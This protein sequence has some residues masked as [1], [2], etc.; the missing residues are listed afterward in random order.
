VAVRRTPVFLDGGGNGLA[1]AALF[2]AAARQ[3]SV[4]LKAVRGG[5]RFDPLGALAEDG[6]LTAGLDRSL[7]LMAHLAAWCDANAPGL[8]ALTVSTVPY[9]TSGA[10]AVQELAYA[11]ATGVLY[12]RHLEER[13]I[14][15]EAGARQLDF[16]F[17]VGRDTFVEM[18]K[19][20]AFRRLW[21]Q[22][23]AACGVDDPAPAPVHAVTSPRTLTTRDPWVNLLRVTSQVFAAV[24]GGAETITTQPF[25]AAVG[26]PGDLGRR[27]A[28]NTHTILREESHLHHVAD[29]AGGSWY[30]E[31]L[32]D[33]L[34]AAG[35]DA[36]RA[37]EADGG[38]RRAFTGGAVAEQLSG[39]LAAA[40][41]DLAT[42]KRPVTG[43][44]TWPN[45]NEKPVKSPAIDAKGLL[46]KRL[47]S[48][49]AW[50]AGHDTGNATKALADATERGDDALM[51][52]AIEAAAQGATATEL[53]DALRSGSRANR[54]V[55]LGCETEAA[56]FERLR[57]AADAHAAEHGQ[58]PR[59]FLATLGPIPE[60]K[61]RATFAKNFFE[62][63]G[64]V[65]T[66]GGALEGT[67]AVVAAYRAAGTDRVCLCSS[68]AR[69]ADQAADVARALK[70]AGAATVLLAGRMGDHE[71]TLPRRRHRRRHLP[72]VRCAGH[73]EP[74]AHRHGG[75][76]MSRI[77]DFAN[78]E[79]PPQSAGDL[80]GW[81]ASART[82]AG[83]DLDQR[84]WATPEGIDVKPLY[85]ADDLEGPCRACPP[86][87]A[88]PTHHVRQR[89]WTIRQ[90]AGFSTAEESNAFYRR[91]LA[92]GQ[93]GLSVA[94]DLATHRGYD[95]D[96]PRVAGDVGMAGV[97]I[98]SIYDMRTLFDGIPLDKMSVSMTMNGAVLPVMALY[99]VAAE[100]QGVSA[101]T[102]RRDHPE[103]H[104]QG[105]HGPQHL[106][107]SARAEHADHRRHLRY[108]ARNMPKFNS[109]SISGYHMQE[110]GA[111]A[112][113]E[114]AYTLADGIE[115][116]RTGVNAGL[117]IDAFAPRL[118]FF[119]AIG[120]NF[121]M[122][123]AKLRAGRLL[124]A[125]IIKEFAPRTPRAWRCAPTARPPAGR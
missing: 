15:P 88:G 80:N 38:M 46:Q 98:D 19:L 120:M 52:L 34:A 89:P 95:S 76:V 64:I 115:Y 58:P 85:T 2:V 24:C 12:L 45:L 57:D 44:S 123:V 75:A 18:A 13:G 8:R 49:D 81:A 54:I 23:L 22:V 91:N 82:A 122:E 6:E 5:F 41:R 10:T 55:P 109:I 53:G 59:L 35:W 3:R 73:P 17:A 30:V 20:R 93:K 40:R 104:P 113:L 79:L 47:G 69:Y 27:M 26:Q 92:A 43:V 84:T 62:A 96:H 110:A 21:S 42:R 60:H 119:W 70:D 74:A 78:L 107:L 100:E 51:D 63:G 32:T 29:P 28:L 39:S 124:W 66:D 111:T 118:S 1:T 71:Q 68:D 103:R 105:V 50:S 94:F 101:E 112:D 87:C 90:Y 25:D 77:P 16:V 48:L 37:I 67:E 86:S 31:R 125:K 4:D 65:T 108:T 106:H 14:A 117:D 11:L 72:R 7:D 97:A 114:L 83:V 99:I 116:V 33:D 121:F 56:G 9:H 61:P 36:F 102:A